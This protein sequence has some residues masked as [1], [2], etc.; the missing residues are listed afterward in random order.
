SLKIA[1]GTV[2]EADEV[3]SHFPDPEVTACVR[4]ALIGSSIPST[5]NELVIVYPLRFGHP[6]D[7][8][9]ARR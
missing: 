3:E 9:D 5:E 7:A 2:R 1:N 8:R 6:P 4:Q